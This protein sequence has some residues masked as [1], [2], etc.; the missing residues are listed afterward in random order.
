[1]DD[2]YNATS[3]RLRPHFEHEQAQK[4]P[5]RLQSDIVWD[6]RADI[7]GLI[8]DDGATLCEV[9]SAV[10]AQG[11]TVLDHGFKAELLK[12]LG[13]VK[14]IRAGRGKNS[15]LALAPTGSVSSAL[16]PVGGTEPAV[17]QH[18]PA[19]DVADDDD[20]FVARRPRG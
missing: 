6:Y 9:V 17:G 7:I 2:T 18:R 13:T 11:E 3:N 5:K 19:E 16:A 15:N 4:P 10:R 12:Q 1:M 8:K 14:D 20:L